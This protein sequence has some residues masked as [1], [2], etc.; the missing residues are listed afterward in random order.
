MIN[1]EELKNSFK[2]LKFD[3]YIA[4][5]IW[6]LVLI[7]VSFFAYNYFISW[8]SFK[9][10]WANFDLWIKK[11]PYNVKSIDISFSDEIDESSISKDIFKITPEIAWV[12]KLKNSNTL[13]YELSNNLE[14]WNDYAIMISNELKSKKWKS[15][16]EDLVYI[17]SAVDWASVLKVLPWDELE[18][19][20]QNM[21]I[22]FSIPMVNFTNV[23]E[24]ENLPCPIE[25]TPKV[26]W[27]C[28]WT[29]T[30][31]LEFVPESH[32]AWATKYDYKIINSDWLNYEL[33]KEFE[34]TFSTPELSLSIPENFIP[35]NYIN[36]HTNYPVEVW[37]LEKHIKIEWIDSLIVEKEFEESDL[38]FLAKPKTWDF[39]YWKVYNLKIEGEIKPKFWNIN[40]KN[41][42]VFV[43]NA[44]SLVSDITPYQNVY[45]STW[46]LID[47]KQITFWNY[48][49][50]YDFLPK[51][52][53][54]FQIKFNEEISLDKSLFSFKSTDNKNINFDIKYA[55]KEDEKWNI[56]DD[57]NTVNL[58]LKDELENNKDYKLVISSK[59]NPNLEKDIVYDYKTS[60]E[61]KI[62]SSKF[63]DY[64]KTCIYTNNKIG[65]EWWNCGD[66]VKN[67]FSFSNSWSIKY[68]NTQNYPDIPWQDYEKYENM[69]LQE[70]ND[71][72]VSNSYC[73]L[74]WTGEYLY[75]VETRLNPNI[76][77]ELSISNLEDKYSNTLKT[78]FKKEVKTWN[79]KEKDKYVYSSFSTFSNVYPDNLPIVLNFQSVNTDDLFVDICEMWEENYIKYLKDPYGN[80]SCDKKTSKTLEAKNNNWNLTNNKYDLE[81]DI[82]GYKS[83]FKYIWVT[84]YPS[85]SKN[86][87]TNF[88][89][90]LI[91]RTNASL[92]LEK[93]ENKWILFATDVKTN[94]IVS[95]L[96]LTFY[97]FDFNK[98]T[99]KYAF[100]KD[101][102][103][104]EVDSDL[105][106]I[107]IVKAENSKYYWI[108]NSD[109]YFSNYDFNY[110]SWMD[111]S[112]KNYLYVYTD[113]PIYRPWDE[114]F[115]KWILRKFDFD[116]F[117]KSHIKTWNLDI[118]DE[119]YSLYRTL[120]V[121]LDENS[122]FTTSFTIP[123]DSILWTFRMEFNPEQSENYEYVYT[124]SFFSIEEYKKPTFKVD[125]KTW[126]SD[127]KLWDKA[128]FSVNPKYYFGWN[129]VNTNGYYTVLS[130]NYF[131]DAKDYSD[132]QFWKSNSYFEC[133]YWWYCEYSDKLED[134]WEFKIWADWN[135]SFDYNFSKTWSWEKL[136]TFSF[137]VT[138]PDTKK[139]VTNSVTKVV[140]TTDNYVWLKTNYYNSLKDWIKSDFVVLDYDAKPV[141]YKTIKID[142]VKRDWNNVKKLWVDW[143]FYNDYSLEEKLEN[144]FTL[145]SDREG[146]ATNTIKTKESWEYEIKA[147]YTWDDGNTFVSSN[148]VYVAWDDYIN[149]RN[150]NNTVTDLSA[151]KMTYKV[152]ETAN[153]TLKS[154]VNNWKALILV[155][156]DD[157]ILDYFVH[158]IKSYW[159]KIEIK[160]WDTYYPNIYVKAYLVWNQPENPLPVYKRA[161]SVVK[162]LTDYKNL[163]ISIKTDKENYS[164]WDKVSF[165]IEVLD[166]NWKVVPNAN[167]SL[168]VVDESVL[169]LK[170]NPKKNP[171]SF[172]YDMKRYL[173]VVTYSNLKYLVE[174]LEIKDVSNWEKWWSW[175]SWVKWWESKK[176]RWNF[177]DTAFWVKDFT[178]DEKWIAKL[179]LEALPDNLTTWV[180]EALVN[181]PTDNKIW[182][183]YET[184]MTAKELMIEDNLPRFLNASDKIILAPVIYNRTWDDARLN[185]KI[186][187]SIWTLW[188]TQKNIFVKNDWSLRVPFE[189]TLPKSSDLSWN[190][191]AQINISVSSWDS[192]KTDSIVKYL[193]VL[194]LET[195]EQVSTFWKTS[196]VSYDEKISFKDI[197]DWNLEIN[198]A[199]TL[200]SW[201]IWVMD[202][203]SSFAYT[204]SEQK[205]SSLMPYIYF[206]NLNEVAWKEYD[207]AK[208]KVKK[209]IDSATWYKEF[210]IDELI[211]DYLIE[212]KKFQNLD[213][214][215]TYF[216]DWNYTKSDIT[217]TNY[218][219]SSLSQ[220]KALWY[221]FDE[222][223]ISNWLDYIKKQFYD[224]KVCGEWNYSNCLSLQTK[225]DIINAIMSVNKDDYEAY[226][227]YKLLD[228]TKAND[229]L[230]KAILLANLSLIKD[231]SEKEKTDL[232]D[233]AIKISQKL[234]SNDLVF[235][236][237]WAFLMWQWDRV[238]SSARFLELLS[239]LWLEKFE[240]IESITDNMIR[241]IMLSKNTNSSFGS[242]FDN[243]QIIK[244]LTTYLETTNEL[245]NT[246]FFARLNLNSKEIDAK[247]ID[248]NNIFEVFWKDIEKKDLKS[249]NIFN[250]EI[251]WSWTLYYDL[252]MSY[253]VD[254]EDAKSV[255]EW[256]F[257]DT[258]YYDYN[259]YKKIYTLKQEEYK[260]YLNWEINYEDLKYKKEVSEYIKPITNWE[261]WQLVLVL[262]KIITNEPRD[263]VSIESYI[264]AWSEIVNTNL[265]TENKQVKNIGSNVLL[266]REEF[267]DDRYFWFLNYLNTWIYDVSYTIRLTHGWSFW[268]APTRVSEFYTPEVFGRSSGFEFFV[269]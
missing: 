178:T 113:R 76:T 88:A 86:D 115:I 142:V 111:S 16:S 107:S 81:T 117:K 140:H 10:S 159:D 108:I 251:T 66:D 215:F 172:F 43:L 45:S 56:I 100:N 149:W 21:A 39:K 52:D 61:L 174:K 195:K 83:D 192:K 91:L 55:K 119:N 170:W 207:L 133:L 246:D 165:E 87:K 51:K 259:E 156:K 176:P 148:I 155:E 49:E 235:N 143:V 186:S 60:P 50:S 179:E 220:I 72:L 82:L 141:S 265:E 44:D 74:A 30:S 145:V 253:Y 41:D 34:G 239:N 256:F 28:K 267:R 79:I 171:Y 214:G 203:N 221:K 185:V 260:K 1:I 70:K 101:K 208:V 99:V 110:I 249:E 48:E 193:Q 18:D 228:L 161:L 129:L 258:K 222:K 196:D 128:N 40:Y 58:E 64:T 9:V 219:L 162:V 38:S 68:I 158:N 63:I 53:V 8:A 97:D 33:E 257:V 67:A 188:E 4:S 201:L 139:T 168:S 136:Y 206:K 80:F 65:C 2:K 187:S 269:R 125:I 98:V 211:K 135:Y 96:D 130:Q 247:N 241:F 121:N 230:D 231:L 209:Y 13:S 245:K 250:A 160:I 29:T 202:Y 59:A 266:D 114:V 198:Y 95:D 116:W 217:L 54:F 46:T 164:P 17:V 183:N 27:K 261:V 255:D 146:L 205:T 25:I 118:Y 62:L 153:F 32:F 3:K 7:F 14:I 264:P 37:E 150:D 248:K 123:K 243:S 5:I 131:Y 69:S 169:A 31:V 197:H 109:D 227:M 24:K 75:A 263:K 151:E 106:N 36:I 93:A 268:V 226:K 138:D 244:S 154:P 213:G 229:E 238:V 92:A 189:L 112:I 84:A 90:N 26:E 127:V 132:Y 120:K 216:Y 175:E 71:Y 42:K 124:N 22:F 223:I 262:N 137:D 173:W 15:L 35:K 190:D 78:P 199:G 240:D 85:Q 225:I 47:T 233:E 134:S 152:W 73:P 23:S 191:I 6:I 182:V 194:P 177:K 252:N 166:K 157:G 234:L 237:R 224:K 105:S 218:I 163:N 242:T 181:T 144:T 94:E 184:I 210:S 104:Y 103:A 232:Q 19:L 236:P 126:E 212:I 180:I 77:Y 204:C 20:S 147:S 57:K 122:N 254:A 102:K 167:W 200:F 11:I 12:V 89:K